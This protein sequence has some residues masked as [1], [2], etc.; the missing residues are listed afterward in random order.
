MKRSAIILTIL[1]PKQGGIISWVQQFATHIKNPVRTNFC[2]KTI[3][4][5]AKMIS[6][7]NG[8]SQPFEELIS[9]IPLDLL[10]GTLKE[11]AGFFFG[12]CTSTLTLQ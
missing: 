10:L 12:R 3:D 8:H 9:T 2:V 11:K 6:F 1:Y 7:T 5:R 4:M